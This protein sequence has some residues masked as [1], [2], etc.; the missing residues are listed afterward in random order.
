MLCFRLGRI[1]R[2]DEINE[3][4]FS[5]FYSRNSWCAICTSIGL[6]DQRHS[7]N[8]WR[9]K[10]KYS[11]DV[12]VR[13]YDWTISKDIELLIIFE[14]GWLGGAVLVGLNLDEEGPM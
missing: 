12:W 6:S 3:I 11:S 13:G 2:D 9:T 8:P 7:G 5:A 4:L 10:Q 1:E 14:R